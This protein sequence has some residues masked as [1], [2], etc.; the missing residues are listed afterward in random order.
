MLEVTFNE[1]GQ[2][3]HQKLIKYDKGRIHEISGIFIKSLNPDELVRVG[4]EEVKFGGKCPTC[5][6][7]ELK[8]YV[9]L[10]RSNDILPVLPLYVCRN[11]KAQ[12][13]YLTDDYLEYLVLNNR[14][15]FSEEELKELDRDKP[16]FIK[17]LKG[18]IIRILASKKISSV[19]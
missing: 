12:S 10:F 3:L 5:G 16:A 19:K 9:E 6:R 18:Y 13:Y 17:E 8:R 1:S 2:I 15:L 11:C 14:E 4:Y 7:S